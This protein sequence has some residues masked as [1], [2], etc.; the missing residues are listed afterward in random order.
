MLSFTL[1]VFLGLLFFQAGSLLSERVANVILGYVPFGNFTMT[2]DVVAAGGPTVSIASPSS[3]IYKV[4][5]V[6]V[7]LSASGSG[8]VDSIW[9]AVDTGSNTTYSTPTSITGLSNGNHTLYAYANFTTGS[10]GSSSVIFLVNT[11]LPWEVNY[12]SLNGTTTNFSQLNRSQQET[13]S[14]AILEASVWGK[15]VFR[16]TVNISRDLSLDGNVLFGNRSVYLDSAD[17]TE[18]N[19][20]A[21]ITFY[22]VTMTSPEILRDGVAC[23]ASVCT[24][25]SYNTTTHQYV[26]NVTG[27]SNYSLQEATVVE[28]ETPAPAAASSGGGGGGGGRTTII[29]RQE[30]VLLEIFVPPLLALDDNETKTSPVILYNRGT[31]KL[32]NIIFSAS[33]DGDVLDADRIRVSTDPLPVTSLAPGEQTSGMITVRTPANMTPGTY[34]IIVSADVGNPK[35]TQIARISI[36]IEQ[37]TE[38][39]ESESQMNFAKNLLDSNPSCA[40]LRELL[41]RAAVEMGKKNYKEARRL[42]DA[43]VSGCQTLLS[44]GS[45]SIERPLRVTNPLTFWF[46]LAAILCGLL[47]L[48]VV[49]QVMLSRKRR[50]F[51]GMS[52]ESVTHT[53][54]RS[55][56]KYLLAV[57]GG[58][59]LVGAIIGVF[60]VLTKRGKQWVASSGS[61]ADSA[62]GFDLGSLVQS[63]TFLWYGGLVVFVI[64]LYFIRK[65]LKGSSGGG[66]SREGGSNK[67]LSNIDAELDRINRE[68]GK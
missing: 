3:A 59:L 5:T 9:Y 2:I 16:T 8:T 58:I 25:I 66:S 51:K 13:I 53:S 34:Q 38:K 64:L 21:N 67:T 17:I 63:S 15:I 68:L 55:H 60:G 26:F 1:V 32:E 18:F 46:M 23:S 29:E 19:Q 48:A 65:V 28:E 56:K 40:E 4:N 27:F 24:L 30:L 54:T 41:D 44:Q 37:S 45:R 31:L 43:A 12:T 49:V 7:S 57:A 20:S 50:I 14:N 11:S 36:T 62:S 22:N 33:V 35:Y 39:R 61:F 47:L 10:V 42:T 6:S 52:H